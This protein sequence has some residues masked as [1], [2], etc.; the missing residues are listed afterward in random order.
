MVN[1][2][3]VENLLLDRAGK[4]ARMGAGVESSLCEGQA[5]RATR[6]EPIALA[7]ILPSSATL[8]ELLMWLR[9][10]LL[11]LVTS[12]IFSL[13]HAAW[14]EPRPPTVERIPKDRHGDPLP[15]RA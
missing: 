10:G 8:R 1:C 5:I 14:S 9:R 15:P 13:S 2:E 4:S 7:L 12:L 3:A 6:C 11:L